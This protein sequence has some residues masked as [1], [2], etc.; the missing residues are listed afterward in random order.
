VVFE[1]Q[2]T[3]VFRQEPNVKLI[4]C[5][6][7]TKHNDCFALAPALLIGEKHTKVKSVTKKIWTKITLLYW[8]AI[9]INLEFL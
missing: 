4:P 2:V 5:E 7:R 1:E 6:N 3:P 9:I 8:W